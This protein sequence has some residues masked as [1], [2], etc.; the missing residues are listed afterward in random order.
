[1][2]N[3]TD[4]LTPEDRAQ[5]SGNLRLAKQFVRELIEHP[6]WHDIL[7]DSAT[8]VLLPGDDPGDHTLS[9]ANVELAQQLRTRGERPILHAVGK[10]SRLGPQQLVEFPIV[11]EDQRHIS[12]DRLRD[13]LTITLVDTDRPTMPIRRNPYI[14]ALVDPETRIIVSLSVP[15]FLAIAAARSI[16]LFDLLLLSSTKLIGITRD[17]VQALRNDVVHGRSEAT[18]KGLSTEE[19]LREINAL[20][21]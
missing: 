9:F 15:N 2:T 6:E 3:N 13:L 1:L 21:A 20:I 19:I 4:E 8:I 17:E 18:G 10:P 5:I 12:Y 11:R 7:P 14:T 16:P